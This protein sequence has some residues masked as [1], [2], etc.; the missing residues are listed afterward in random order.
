MRLIDADEVIEILK[1]TGII[2]DNELGHCVI[3]EINRIPTAYDVEKV[4]EELESEREYAHADFEEY[5][6][7]HGIDTED[8]WLYAGIK[9]ALEIVKAGNKIEI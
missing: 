7:L 1:E 4:V 9:R 2:Q 3:A 8:D 5:A 6:E